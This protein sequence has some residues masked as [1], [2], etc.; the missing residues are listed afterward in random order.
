MDIFEAFSTLGIPVTKKIPDIKKAYQGR[1]PHHHPEEDPEGFMLLHEAY[2]TALN[3]AKENHSVQSAHATIMVHADTPADTQEE[4]DYSSLFAELDEKVS[5]HSPQSR[6]VFRRKLLALKLH[7]G[8]ISVTKW[9]TFFSSEAYLLCRKDPDCMKKLYDL[10][11]DKAHS[12]SA[13]HFLLNQVWELILWQQSEEAYTLAESTQNL[14]NAL[15]NLYRHY[16]KL[17]TRPQGLQKLLPAVWYYEVIPFCLK[18]LVMGFVIPLLSFGSATIWLIL[19][20]G[21]FLLE[22]VIWIL[23]ISRSIGIFRIR[24]LKK[25]HNTYVRRRSDHFIYMIIVIFALIFHFGI[26]TQIMMRLV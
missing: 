1:L 19:S 6:K 18:L 12:Y 25:R 13:L 3:Y 10:L 2:Q 9:R 23:N 16:L 26:S 21:F 20:C 22:F 15:N 17:D 24:I 5:G 8:P 7:W 14:L 4:T 11:L